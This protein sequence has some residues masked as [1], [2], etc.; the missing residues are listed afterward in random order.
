MVHEEKL[1]HQALTGKKEKLENKVLLVI[2]EAPER[3]EKRV[4]QENQDIQET[5]AIE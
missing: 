4:P 3:R 5:R 1:A 2:L